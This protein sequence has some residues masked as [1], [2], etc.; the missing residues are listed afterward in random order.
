MVI[1]SL[2]TKCK[3]SWAIARFQFFYQP[4]RYYGSIG[5][6]QIVKRDNVEALSLRQTSLVKKRKKKRKK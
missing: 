2:A 3:P 5:R 4:E 1:I 6:S